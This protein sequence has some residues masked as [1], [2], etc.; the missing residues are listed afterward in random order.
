MVQFTIKLNL[1]DPTVPVAESSD[2]VYCQKFLIV[3]T[4]GR[5]SAD[6]PVI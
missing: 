4:D 3:R 2:E 5:F 1:S 6:H